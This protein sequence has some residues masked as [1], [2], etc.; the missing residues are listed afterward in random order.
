MADKIK[1]PFG[2]PDVMKP[3]YAATI[4]LTI[5]NQLTVI[6]VALTGALTLNLTV[7][8]QV[9]VGAE[10]ILELSSDGT[11]RDTTL[12]TAIDGPVVA[13]VINKTKS[14]AFYLAEDGVFKPKGAQV[15]VD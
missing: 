9:S 13:G 15:Q 5:L 14:Q 1:H 11:A 6:K 2:A 8:P 4:A 3:A 7:D 12:G 10:L